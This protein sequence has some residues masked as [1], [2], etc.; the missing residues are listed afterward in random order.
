MEVYSHYKECHRVVEC[1]QFQTDGK[2]ESLVRILSNWIM[3]SALGLLGLWSICMVG[4]D[5]NILPSLVGLK[6]KM[7][8]PVV[9]SFS[10]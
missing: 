5:S 6:T 7:Q 3:D 8:A 9:L 4:T 2:A 10:T 1:V